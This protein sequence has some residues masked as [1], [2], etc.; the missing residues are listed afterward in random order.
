M[1][2]YRLYKILTL[3]AAGG[4]V[5]QT[6]TGCANAEFLNTLLRY[7]VATAVSISFSKW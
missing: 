5:F 3:V 2:L 7:A 4:L 6:T 1:K